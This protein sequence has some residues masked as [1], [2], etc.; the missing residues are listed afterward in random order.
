MYFVVQENMFKET[1]YQMMIEIL[2]KFKFDYEIVKFIPFCHDIEFK[3]ERKDVWVWGTA[4]MALVAHKYGWTP[5]SMY[6]ENH[7]L[8]VYAAYYKE[9]MLNSDGVIMK[10]GDKLPPHE[11]F[12]YFFARPTK[13]TKAFSG[14]LFS[15]EAW[16]EYTK[17]AESNNTL[18]ILN[19]ETKV[20][21]APLKTIQQEIRCWIVGGKVVTI[22]LYK[23]G[24]RVKYQNYDHESAAIEFAQKMVDLYCP[25]EAFVLDICLHNDEYKVVEVNNINS[26]GFYHCNVQRLIEAIENH[27][28]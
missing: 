11:A 2:E 25:A 9:H 6:N 10:F 28:S 1:H 24:S 13:D 26:A 12:D 27:F 4:N 3:T 18:S 17:N 7:D 22:S 19:D 8:E 21:V 23:I 15:R 20:L 14:Q 16:N 5:G